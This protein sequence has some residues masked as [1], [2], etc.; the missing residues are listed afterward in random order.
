MG[1]PLMFSFFFPVS[2]AL[3]AREALA[4]DLCSEEISKTGASL[5]YVALTYLF[6]FVCFVCFCLFCFV[7]FFSL[8]I[9][10]KVLTFLNGERFVGFCQCL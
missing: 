4:E 10:F 7:L 3:E 9:L 5:Q 1:F 6:V 8:M 2:E